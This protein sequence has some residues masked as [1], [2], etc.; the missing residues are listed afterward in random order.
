VSEVAPPSAAD[1]L[2]GQVIADRYHVLSRIG[3]GGMGR[4]YAAEHVRMGRRSAVKV[5]SP[6]LALAADAISRFN[7][8]AAN[9]SR[10]N[11]PN[12]AQIYDFG[13]TST[14]LLYLAMELIEG[15]TLRALVES[16]GPLPLA[17]AAHLASQIADGLAAAHHLGI[18]HRDLKPDNVMI[19][20]RHDGADWVKLV[21][22]GIAKSIR[23][24]GDAPSQ[25]VTTAG[26]SLGTPEYMSPEQL[27]GEALDART[28]LYS[29]ALLLFNM[30]TGDLP[31]PRVTSRD[32]L[33]RRL[34]SRPRTLAEV[35]PRVRWPAALQRA[36][37][38]ALAPHADE[39]HADVAA[40][41]REVTAAVSGAAATVRLEPMGHGTSEAT[42]HLSGVAPTLVAPPRPRRARV[43]AIA[44]A[45][46]VV[47]AIA[48]S[49]MAANRPRASAESMPPIERQIRAHAFR[50]GMLV[51]RGNVA[52]S[53]TELRDMAKELQI[54]RTLYPSAADSLQIEQQAR[55]AA[56][57]VVERCRELASNAVTSPLPSG[58]ECDELIAQGRRGRGLRG[59]RDGTSP[60][61]R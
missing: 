34:T 1:P 26:V 43:P 47:L 53:R 51:D 28:D 12:V 24:S 33:V 42:R 16:T 23:G 59:G 49:A 8:E 2:V 3:E 56:Q 37:D 19:T 9:A 14:G 29:L 58:F 41:A 31:Y 35:A 45:L 13:E 17:R 15:R 57:R 11:H 50:A 48:G 22:F 4:V 36:L 32:T 18:V 39:R 6:S 52:G 7:R 38:R 5:M 44:G 61:P 54:F 55:A 60:H 27:A 46:L 20:Q 40:F 30:L 10:I 21:D 25:T